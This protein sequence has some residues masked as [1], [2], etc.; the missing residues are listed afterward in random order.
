MLIGHKKIL[1]RLKI[2]ASAKTLHHAQIFLGPKGVGKSKVALMLAMHMQCPDES[3]IVLRKQIAEGADFDT[4]ICADDDEVLP[5]EKIRE[6]IGRI[7]Q[8]HTKPHLIFII[9]NI[10]RMRI[11][12]MN[13]LLKTLEEPPMD[14]YFF[15]TAENES[16]IIPTIRSRSKIVNFQ[17]VPEKEIY[18]ACRDNAY[19]EELVKFAVG[20]PGKLMRLMNDQEYF[21]LHRSMFSDLNRFLERPNLPAIFE[22]VRKYEIKSD[23]KKTKLAAKEFLDLLITRVRSIMLSG[24]ISPALSHLDF[25]EVVDR[26]EIAKSDIMGNVNVKL[27]LENLLI[28]FVA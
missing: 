27:V 23:S 5:I 16:D 2:E 7:G 19:H 13:A 18:E 9:E 26:I 1:E 12:S 22:M 10:G 25:T 17:S 21:E 15:M 4:I 6:L 8:S 24:E 14:T 20:K 11:E 28:P 3:Q